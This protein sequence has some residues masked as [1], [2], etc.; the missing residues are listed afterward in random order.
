MIKF[1]K[2]SFSLNKRKTKKKPFFIFKKKI[3]ENK[4]LRSKKEERKVIKSGKFYIRKTNTIKRKK[5]KK[6]ITF[7]NKKIEYN[8]YIRIIPN[9][10]FCTLKDNERNKTIILISGGILK[11]KIS[12]KKLK[13]VNKLLIEKF[14]YKIKNKLKHKTCVLKISGPKKIIKF[15][16]K[17]LIFSLNKSKILINA[18]NKKIFN[19]C[20]AKKIRRKKRKGLRILK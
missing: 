5:L 20:R 16:T 15:V 17:Q 9:N 1:K 6:I 18:L 13:Y 11:L 12:K 10:I 8:I 14:I 19:G 7:F 2:K 3:L 4:R